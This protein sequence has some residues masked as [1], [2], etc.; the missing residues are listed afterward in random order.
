MLGYNSSTRLN[1]K[2]QI[3]TDF[4]AILK[5]LK[6]DNLMFENFTE[7]MG[8]DP[9]RKLLHCLNINPAKFTQIYSL[10][11]KFCP[12]DFRLYNEWGKGEVMY[13]I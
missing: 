5:S 13:A 6:T 11:W 1:G 9:S 2:R 8:V 12:N 10:S 3:K 7:N 4:K